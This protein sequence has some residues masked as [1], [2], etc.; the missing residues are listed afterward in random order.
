[1]KRKMIVNLAEGTKNIRIEH[2]VTVLSVKGAL[3][4]AERTCRQYVVPGVTALESIWFYEEEG[5]SRHEIDGYQPLPRVGREIPPP[6]K[7]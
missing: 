3:D 6:K 2:D 7:P 1:M 5:T 4:V